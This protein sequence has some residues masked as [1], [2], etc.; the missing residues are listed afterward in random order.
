LS[1]LKIFHSQSNEKILKKLI[2]K[3]LGDTYKAPTSVAKSIY[4]KFEEGFAKWWEN[5]ENVEWFSNNAQLWQDLVTHLI[6]EISEPAL[7]KSV[8]Y[9][10]HFNQQQIQRLY[11]AI[12]HNT[13]F[14]IVTNSDIRY[15]QHLK[16]DQSLNNVGYTN[17]LPLGLKSLIN[18]PKEILNLWHS[19]WS[20]TLV[21]DCDRDCNVA[22][23]LFHILQVSCL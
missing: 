3:E 8:A 2:V 4:T 7:Q 21:I 9:G 15:L 13:V 19:K 17:S 6:T 18:S 1:K 5:V 12:K 14:N 11:D 20:A 10:I 22:D 16:T 23:I